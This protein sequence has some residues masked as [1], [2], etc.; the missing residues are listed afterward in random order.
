MPR[1]A[2]IAGASGGIG[3]S[4]AGQLLQNGYAVARMSRSVREEKS[5]MALAV[6]CD[7][8]R[9]DSVFGAV[10]EV[11]SHFGRIDLFVNSVGIALA[12]RVEDLTEEDMTLM[13]G[14]NV[15]GALWLYQAVMGPMK[16]QGSG[17]IIHIGSMRADSPGIAKAAYCATKAAAT[18][19]TLVL[20]RECR[21]SGIRVTTIHPGYVD[22]KLYKGISQ[23]IPFRGALRNGVLN[24]K[25]FTEVVEA[26]DVAKTVIWLASLSETALVAEIRL[27][28]PWGS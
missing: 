22:T 16:K 7:V 11:L 6:K 23:K 25:Y 21:D 2:L 15:M 20:A 24:V 17:Y 18:Q 19:L 14:T 5:A 9:R 12:K 13:F 28:R 8:T 4:V 26:A 10:G 1:V 3:S 27:G